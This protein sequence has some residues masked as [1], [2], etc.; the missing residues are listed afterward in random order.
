M[1][2]TAHK[3]HTKHS[4]RPKKTKSHKRGG[5]SKTKKHRKVF[6]VMVGGQDREPFESN[7]I[8]G[9]ASDSM[10]YILTN[11]VKLSSNMVAAS[12]GYTPVNNNL[13]QPGSAEQSAVYE[14][15]QQGLQIAKIPIDVFMKMIDGVASQYI[16]I[17]NGAMKINAPMIQ[18]SLTLTIRILK[19]HDTLATSALR[20]PAFISVLRTT[21]TA[22]EEA[23]DEIVGV[24]DPVAASILSK[25][26]P[27]I[28]RSIGMLFATIGTSA[29]SGAQSMPYVGTVL[30][31]LSSFD[32][33]S[34]LFM[35]SINAATATGTVM[36]DG[37]TDTVYQLSDMIKGIKNRI[38][39]TTSG[40]SNAMTAM[41]NMPSMPN[42]PNMPSMP[43]AP[44]MPTAP[45]MPTAPKIKKK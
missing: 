20:N 6:H 2:M 29:L 18:A 5:R 12:I 35:S 3:K 11:V 7:G 13:G 39:G 1:S 38:S 26:S 19:T 16:K 21:L 37:Y 17:L 32:A 22:L 27:I 44:N 25:L 45:A 36:L 9:M 14:K 8:F 30:A 40:M 43:D 41:P 34:R 23:S 24:I 15:L 33:V 10:L 31:A 4:S 28:S 42:A